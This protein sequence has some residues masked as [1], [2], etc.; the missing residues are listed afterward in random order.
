MIGNPGR[1]GMPLEF[2]TYE[3]AE[4]FLGWLLTVK[5]AIA[6]TEAAKGISVSGNLLRLD[7][8]ELLHVDLDGLR[9]G[10]R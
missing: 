2:A 6:G 8:E 4:G 3:E 9:V 7:S 1:H 10:V 5:P